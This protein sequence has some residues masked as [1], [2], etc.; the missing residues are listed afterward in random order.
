MNRQK[1]AL[2]ALALCV[3]LMAAALLL[4]LGDQQK[5]WEDLPYTLLEF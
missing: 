3:L 2:C 5:T 4:G 1:K